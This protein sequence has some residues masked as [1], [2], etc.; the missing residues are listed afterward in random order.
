MDEKIVYKTMQKEVHLNSLHHKKEKEITKLF[1][2][3]IQFKKNKID[4]YSILVHKKKPRC[5][6]IGK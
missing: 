5:R 1:H 6:G 4:F 2:V 3:K